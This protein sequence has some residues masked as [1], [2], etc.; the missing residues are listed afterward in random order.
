MTSTLRGDAPCG[1]RKPNTIVMRAFGDG[2]DQSGAGN[3]R[4]PPAKGGK[5]GTWRAKMFRGAHA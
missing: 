3:G 5:P 1:S 2:Q 4:C